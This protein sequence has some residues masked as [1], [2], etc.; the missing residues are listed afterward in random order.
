[1]ESRDDSGVFVVRSWSFVK[2]IST[3]DSR[4]SG[5]ERSKSLADSSLLEHS[6]RCMA[7]LHMLINDKPSVRDRTK[8]DLVVAL[9]LSLETAVVIQQ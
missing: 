7:R 3:N 4:T 1:M 8:P 6:V 9:S 2:T 5:R